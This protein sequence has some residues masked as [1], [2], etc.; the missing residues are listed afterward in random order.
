MYADDRTRLRHMLDAAREAVAIGAG[1][2]RDDLAADRVLALALVKLIEVVGEAATRVTRELQRAH[3]EIPWR[4]ITGMR[5][6]LVH[7]YDRIDPERVWSTVATDLPALIAALE[8]LVP[9][10]ERPAER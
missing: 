4:Q 3:P 10:D 2:S 6:V 9:P 1:R 8:P 5:H 7:D